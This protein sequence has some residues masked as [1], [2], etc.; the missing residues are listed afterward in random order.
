MLM[1]IIMMIMI[2]NGARQRSMKCIALSTSICS[3]QWSSASYESYDMMIKPN[4]RNL[5][6]LLTGLARSSPFVRA[7]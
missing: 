3:G 7:F 1:F 5:E 4:M 2:N 6:L